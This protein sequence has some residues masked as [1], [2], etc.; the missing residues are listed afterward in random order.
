[1]NV[2]EEISRDRLRQENGDLRSNVKAVA[3]LKWFDNRAETPF[4]FYSIEFDDDEDM[5]DTPYCVWAPHENVGHHATE[6]D[7]RTSAQADYEKRLM[8]ALTPSPQSRATGEEALYPAMKEALSAAE[9]ALPAIHHAS[10]LEVVYCNAFRRGWAAAIASPDINVDVE[11]V[12]RRIYEDAHKGMS[13]IWGWD[14]GGLDDEHPGTRYRYL[15]YAQSAIDALTPPA[16]QDQQAGANSWHTACVNV[17][18]SKAETYKL[19]EEVKEFAEALERGEAFPASGEEASPSN[20]ESETAPK[21][22]FRISVTGPDG[23]QIALSHWPEGYALERHGKIVWREDLPEMV[24][25]DV[26]FADLAYELDEITGSDEDSLRRREFLV[27]A[28]RLRKAELRGAVSQ[29]DGH[30]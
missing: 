4:G 1:M 23:C 15:K 30:A 25:G 10:G 7:A 9:R 2:D 3:T 21:I 11:D 26:S 27:K 13:N 14:D 24:G 18:W 28:I 22:D 8:S 16:P 29:G 20:Q 17:L 19:F 6:A 12:A 5:T